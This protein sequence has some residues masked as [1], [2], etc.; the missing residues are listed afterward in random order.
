ML[1]EGY[2]LYKSLQRCGIQLKS[3]HPD[4]KKPGKADGLI[5][6][7][8]KN[9]EVGSVEYCPGE[10]AAQLW[11]IRKGNH[12]SF[13]IIK[14]Q[15]PLWEV[16]LNDTLR[17]KLD[18][19]KDE[20]AKRLL[21]ITEER[22]VNTPRN[23]V[24][25][26]QQEVKLLQPY[27]KSNDHT[28][29]A[30]YELISRFLR[31]KGTESFAN[32]LLRQ[33]KKT[34]TE[35]SYSLIE[36]TFIGKWNA[37]TGEFRAEVPLILDLSD[38]EKFSVRIASP[39][40]ES[41]ISDCLFKRVRLENNVGQSAL[42]GEYLPLE[43]DKF[44]NP[45]LPIVGNTYLFSVNPDTPCQSR[46]GRNSTDLC[47]VG[48]DE[49]IAIQDALNWITQEVRKGATWYGMPGTVASKND[50]LIVYLENKPNAEVKN[51]HLLG[52]VTEN[53]FSESMYEKI[54]KVA[55]EALKGREIVRAND[56]IRLFALRRLDAGRVQISLSRTYTVG[57]LIK[58]DEDWRK[59]WKNHPH[60]TM[61]FFR[62]EIEKLLRK[63]GRNDTAIS[64]YAN[65]PN[66]KPA[67]LTPLCPFPG[68]LLKITQHQWS[69]FGKKAIPVNGVSAGDIYDVFFAGE[70]KQRRL[71]ENLLDLTLQRT[72]PLLIGIGGAARRQEEKTYKDNAR[73]TTLTVVAALAIYLYKLGIKKE[74]YMKDT[75]FYIGQFLSVVDTLHHEYCKHVRGSVPPQLLGNAHLQIALDNPE[76]AIE[77]MS[78]RLRVYQAWARTG[79]GE[80]MRLA[81]WALGQ[82]SK[83][84]S[85]LAEIPLPSST[86]SSDRAQIL[87]GYLAKPESIQ[88]NEAT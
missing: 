16:D 72:L 59:A 31:V 29:D 84:C 35:I 56:L 67:L 75:F 88:V 87:L 80:E 10:K 22:E 19:T 60:I 38:W 61:P 21:L 78:S 17:V 69:R 14:L 6:G 12:R 70:G 53:Y 11:T 9:G 46:Y 3:R 44:P 86:T 74:V 5:V 36:K 81:R 71:I 47:P 40:M 30:M 64:E 48:R 57:Q 18:K 73:F 41:F 7:L 65:N 4:I 83:I 27:F 32:G 45:N 52:G 33:I 49:A 62:R 26:L 13:P 77:L 15:H 66:T 20:A 43:D 79:Q 2:V 76:S 1:N 50:L 28:Y 23:W 51:A 42:S 58:A 63:A 68:D 39:Q 8:D 24:G 37:K 55:I 82:L 25:K 54:A 34:Q 85:Q